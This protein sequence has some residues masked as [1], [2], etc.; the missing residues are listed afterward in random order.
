M[1]RLCRAI[2][3]LLLSMALPAVAQTLTV[4]IDVE[5]PSLDPHFRMLSPDEAVSRHFFDALILQDERQRMLPGLALSWRAVDETTWDFQLRPSVEFADGSKFTAEDVAYSLKRPPTVRNAAGGYQLFTRGISE[6]EI[7]DPLR[8]RVHTVTP[9]PTLPRELSVIWIVSHR[10]GDAA[11]ADFD[12]GKAMI[13][14][15]PFSLVEWRKGERIA[16]TRNERYWGRKP[17]WKEVVLRPIP[18]DS[19]RVAALLAHDVDAISAVPPSAIPELKNRAGIRLVETGSARP[20]FLD[21][22]TYSD[23]SPY[24]TDRNGD[25][26]DRNPL[27]DARVRIAISKSIDRR[28]IIARILEGAGEPASQMLPP[29]YYGASPLLEPEAY[30]PEGARRLLTEA[31]YPQGFGISLHVSTSRTPFD[32]KVA[33]AVAEMTSRIGIATKVVSLPDSILRTRAINHE[34][35]FMLFGYYSETAEPSPWLRGIVATIDPVRGWGYV[36]RGRHSIPE[37]DR[38]LEQ[39]LATIDDDRREQLLRKATEIAIGQAV[40]VPL[41]HAGAVWALRDGLTY[42]P[43]KDTYTLSQDIVP[44]P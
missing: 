29:G 12:S 5:P 7:L 4:G 16:L 9:D 28:G 37:V 44:A 14:T 35:S 1:G 13:G 20:T 41:F 33:V 27:K 36:N 43:R 10:A 19:A 24:V 42:V 18:N 3:P 40:I 23:R 21:F 25:P 31:G 15:G 22:D 38:L 26:L 39:G 30:D 17:V 34:L 11:S 2:L 32:E 8:V 6:V